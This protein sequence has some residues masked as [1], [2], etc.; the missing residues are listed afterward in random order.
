ML[1]TDD[2]VDPQFAAAMWRLIGDHPQA[3]FFHSPLRGRTIGMPLPGQVYRW[4]RMRGGGPNGSPA[5]QVYRA[6]IEAARHALSQGVRIPTIVI[7]RP[8]ACSIPGMRADLLSPADEEYVVRLARAGDV[9]YWGEALCI[10]TRHA[11]QYSLATWLEPGFVADYRRVHEEA[12]RALGSAGTAADRA[13]AMGAW[14]T[15]PAAWRWPGLW[16]A[17]RAC[18]PCATPPDRPGDH[19]D[20]AYRRTRLIVHSRPAKWL[21]RRFFG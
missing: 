19:R 16:P 4:L 21:Y 9:V 17:R 2:L 13:A 15:W 7:Y 3:A 18:G 10:Y 20:T 8:T 1:H 12:F 5:V 6:G 11:G 14:P